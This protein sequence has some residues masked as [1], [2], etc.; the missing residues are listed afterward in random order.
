MNIKFIPPN[1]Q[2]LKPILS[3]YTGVIPLRDQV[4]GAMQNYFQHLDGFSSANLYQMVLS[5]VEPPLLETV[6]EYTR[7]NQSRAAILLGISRSTLR[8]KLA[9]YGLDK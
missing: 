2:D 7:G 1:E 6:L 3:D 4:R 9:I 8:K 5:E